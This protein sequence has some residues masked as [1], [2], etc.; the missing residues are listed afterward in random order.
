MQKPAGTF[1]WLQKKSFPFFLQWPEHVRAALHDTIV[2]WLQTA[3]F[4]AGLVP[5]RSAR[6]APMAPPAVLETEPACAYQ[7]SCISDASNR[8]GTGSVTTASLM[9]T[10]STWCI[11]ARRWDAEIAS[12]AV[13]KP[14]LR[15]VSLWVHAAGSGWPDSTGWFL[16]AWVPGKAATK[17]SSTCR[18]SSAI[19]SDIPA[20]VAAPDVRN[21]ASPAGG[22]VALAVTLKLWPPQFVSAVYRAPKP[23]NSMFQACWC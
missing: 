5:C 3:Y 13:V 20:C 10:G 23:A 19:F 2:H 21:M 16:N 7:G 4:Q 1:F 22:P 11:S 18:R 17:Q 9:S 15:P 14:S 8:A 12:R 6:C